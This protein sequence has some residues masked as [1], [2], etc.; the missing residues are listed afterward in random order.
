[1]KKEYPMK[2]CN[3]EIIKATATMKKLNQVVLCVNV[4][5]GSTFATQIGDLKSEAQK[6]NDELSIPQ[7]GARKAAQT[8][9]AQTG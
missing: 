2:Q 1:M 3:P 7:S 8:A 4:L 5:E 6:S 9:V